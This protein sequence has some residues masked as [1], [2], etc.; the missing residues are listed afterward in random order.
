MNKKYKRIDIVFEN[1]ESIEIPSEDI[2]LFYA[3]LGN[4][5]MFTNWSC[6]RKNKNSFII[7]HTNADFI[8]M[9]IKL[10][11][12]SEEHKKYLLTR[13]DIT[14][15]DIIYSDNSNEYIR[16]PEPSLY[17]YWF[18]NPYQTILLEN[19]FDKN[20]EVVHLYFKQHFSF[21]FLKLLVKDWLI[22]W[23]RRI[24]I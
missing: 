13:K 15:I 2:N 3:E 19:A 22:Y 18:S 6:N 20:K 8:S 9:A 21:S 23:Y 4:K 1:C 7:G 5:T 17:N 11:D 12:L 16:V 14:H 24:C 10:K